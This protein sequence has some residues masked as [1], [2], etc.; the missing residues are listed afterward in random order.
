[1]KPRVA[2]V[3]LNWN[4]WRDT[5][6]CLASLQHL[7]YPNYEVVVVDNGSTDGSP[8]RIHDR[9]PDVTVLE[10]GANLGYAGGNNVGLRY[11]L[12]RGAEGVLLLNDDTEVA[13]DLLSRLVEGTESEERV[14]AAGPTIYYYDPP[15]LIWSAGGRIDSRRGR[16]SIL[17]LDEADYG[18]LGDEPREVDFA[19]GCALWM[20]RQALRRV[21]LLDE[22]FFAYF[23]EIEWCARARRAG[24]RVLHVPLAHVW[25]KVPHDA[26]ESSPGVHYYM[27]R[28]RLL[29]LRLAGAGW[30]AWLHTLGGEYLR[31]LCSWTL[32]PRWRGKRAQRAATVRGI[33]DFFRGRWGMYESEVTP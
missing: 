1:M 9:F 33:V 2:I 19:T 23:E 16:T 4:N 30:R 8:E 7:D 5:A 14:A 32:R 20:S 25:H 15:H 12:A 13:P 27:T 29:F 6:E 18:Q 3:V 26:R 11:A 22:R 28:N 24:F 31:R 10:N 17:S 21:G